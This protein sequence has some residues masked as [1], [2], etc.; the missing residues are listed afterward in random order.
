MNI[1]D[2]AAVEA[3]LRQDGSKK[4]A[5]GVGW[6]GASA[7]IRHCGSPIHRRDLSG[8]KKIPFTDLEQLFPTKYA[9]VV[10]ALTTEGGTQT[11]YLGSPEKTTSSK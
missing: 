5:A 2:L 8:W 4:Y 9:E 1:N 7:D 11:Y 6:D 10:K 3:T